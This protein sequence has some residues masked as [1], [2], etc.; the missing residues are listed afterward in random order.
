MMNTLTPLSACSRRALARGLVLL[1]LVALPGLVLSG[2]RGG[3]RGSQPAQ[4]RNASEAVSGRWTVTLNPDLVEQGVAPLT[5]PL[6]LQVSAMAEDQ[7]TLTGTLADAELSEGSLSSAGAEP[8]V[9]FTTGTIS[10]DEDLTTQ[11]PLN[12]TGTLQNGR[13]YGEVVGPD[14]RTGRW[15]ATKN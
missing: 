10:P 3:N 8:T 7:A 13:L 5:V 9:R 4:P 1:A 12:W 2:C 15:M 14:G 6:S 11:G